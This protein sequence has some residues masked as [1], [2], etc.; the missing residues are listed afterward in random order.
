MEELEEALRE[1]V[2]ITAQREM[3]MAEQ[4]VKIEQQE[5]QVGG[6]SALWES[7]GHGLSIGLSI[8]GTVVQFHLPP[9]QNLSNFIHPT[10]ACVF[11]K[12]HY[13]PVVPSIWCLCQGK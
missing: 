9:F 3:V 1:S 4:H 12:R 5:K 7:D 8:E 2:K 11:R 13:K 6:R 10:F